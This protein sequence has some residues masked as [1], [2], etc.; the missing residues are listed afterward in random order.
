MGLCFIKSTRYCA[1]M[2]LHS[3]SRKKG[4]SGGSLRGDNPEPEFSTPGPAGNK[5]G[6]GLEVL[7][8]RFSTWDKYQCRWAIRDNG[9]LAVKCKKNGAKGVACEY[10]ANPRSCPEYLSNPR[11]YWKQVERSLKRQKKI[12]QGDAS[13]IRTR[14]C[15]NAGDEAHFR[16]HR[17]TPGSPEEGEP[18]PHRMDKHKL[19]EE[20]CKK[21]WS[22]FCTFFFYMIQ[23]DC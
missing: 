3:R 10:T 8:G 15:R 14:M 17:L 4:R 22:S 5:N 23:N 13:P 12:C 19:S 16:L 9:G 6:P 2:I 1:S 20:F 7:R 11:A 21:Q 18:C